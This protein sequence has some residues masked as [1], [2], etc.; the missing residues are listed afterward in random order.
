MRR[1]VRMQSM[2]DDK[3]AKGQG[4]REKERDVSESIALGKAVRSVLPSLAP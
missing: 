2:K 4:E 1:E 3:R